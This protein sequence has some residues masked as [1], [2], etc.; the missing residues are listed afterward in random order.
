MKKPAFTNFIGASMHEFGNKTL[1]GPSTL[2][3]LTS[4]GMQRQKSLGNKSFN[5]RGGV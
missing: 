2:Q 3:N 4:Q 1:L 5:S